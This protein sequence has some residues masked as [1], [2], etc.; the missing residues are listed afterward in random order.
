ME[1]Y[2]DWRPEPTRLAR[3]MRVIGAFTQLALVV[4][5]LAALAVLRTEWRQRSLIQNAIAAPDSVDL[6]SI[7]A[8]DNAAI[9]AGDFQVA[10]MI[11]TGILFIAWLYRARQNAEGFNSGM[12]RRGPRWAIGG[13]FVPIMN[14]WVPYQVVN[15]TL[16]ATEA[17][18]GER[19]GYGLI[20]AWW[21]TW[22][23]AALGLQ[24]FAAQG[25]PSTAEGFVSQRLV[26]A[27]LQVVVVVAAVLAILVVGRITGAS[28]RKVVLGRSP[29]GLP[30]AV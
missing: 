3:P 27:W 26:G 1:R 6:G 4:S 22:L 21:M 18:P 11:V 14:L 7:T 20:R 30:V 28:E 8:A 15:D 24:I 17:K 2:G 19:H 16:L 12:H 10:A 29:G 23:A 13:W 9:T 25:D 5:L